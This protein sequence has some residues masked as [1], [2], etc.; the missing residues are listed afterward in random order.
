MFRQKKYL[1]KDPQYVFDFIDQHPFASFVLQGED[2]LA[3]HIPVL[4]EGT[5]EKFRL[6]GHIA[7]ANEQYKFLKDGLDALLIF[8]GAHGYV[9]SSWYKDINISTWDY[10]AVHVNVKLK[11][12]S[13]QELEESL[14]KLIGRFEK[15]QKCP[16]FYKDLPREM[17]DDHLPLITGFWC[18]PV[19]VQAIVKLHQGF[20]KDDVNSVSE[21]LEARQDPLSS[22]LSKNIKKEHGTGY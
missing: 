11:L 5:P 9:S 20:D 16:I 21:H 22:T 17:I 18:E 1:K 3:T 14:Q 15:E 7:E 10:S 19:K 2:L 6:Y 4:I 13:Q 8:H 12:Q